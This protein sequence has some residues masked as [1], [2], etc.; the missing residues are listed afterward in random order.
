[1]FNSIL[2]YDS[3][4]NSLKDQKARLINDL[5]TSIAGNTAVMVQLTEKNVEL[6]QLVTEAQSI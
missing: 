2:P 1:M 6:N 4:I 3:R 5:K